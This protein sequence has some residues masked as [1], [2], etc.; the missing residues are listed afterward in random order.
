MGEV[1]RARDTRLDRAVAIKVLP[2]RLSGTTSMR[3]RFEREVRTVSQLSHPNICAVYDVGRDGDMG[4]VVM[5]YLD[6]ETLAQRIAKGPLPLH[7]AVRIAAQLADALDQ[8]HRR[9]I[10]HRDVKPGNVMLTRSGAKL[11]DFGL[12]KTAPTLVGGGDSGSDH[13]ALATQAH[14]TD[15]GTI[16]GTVQYMAPE[17]LEGREA[18]ARTDIFALGTV[19]YEMVTGRKAFEASS[20]ASVIISIMSTTPP[21]LSSV[22]P[23]VPPLL[24][25][26]VHAC[27]EKDP[28]DRVQT[29]HDVLLQLRWIQESSH[30]STLADRPATSSIVRRAVA[31]TWVP[32]TIAATTM[33]GAAWL[34]VPRSQA[35]AETAPP[36]RSSILL[37]ERIALAS[38]A[39]SPAGDRIVFSG[40]DQT[41]RNQLWVRPLDSE[42]ATRLAGT[43]GGILPFWSPD[44]KDIGF[45]A[46]KTLKR[47]DVTG[48]APVSLYG[49][50]GVSGTWT[51]RGDI[52]FSG[53]TG[54]ILRIAAD[55]GKASPVTA[56]DARRG[57]T[58]HRYPAMLPD[59]R[60][61]LFLAMNPASTPADPTNQI[62]VGTLDGAPTKSLLPAS[63]NPLYANGFLL[64]TRGSADGGSLLAQP[65]D[66]TR[67]E[68]TG[69]VTTV[70]S[71]VAV[72]GEFAGL[73]SVSVST[74]GTL[75]FDASRQLTRLAFYDRAGR[76]TA[77]FGEPALR[78]NPSLAPDGTHV[79]YNVYD[80]NNQT[81]QIW[82]ADL[83]R[84]VETR[85]T[86]PPGSSRVP[87][88]SPDGTRIAYQSDAKHQEDIMIRLADGSGAVEAITDEAG[89]HMVQ[90]FSAD[91]RTLI[92]YDREP[93]GE[94]LVGITAYPL[95]GDRKSYPVVP[96]RSDNIGRIG[97]A[98]LSPDGRWLAYNTDESGRW[99]VVV[100]SFPAGKNKVQISNA[101]GANP[102]WTRAGRELLYDAPDKQI[103]SVAILPGRFQAA[104]PMPLFMK[105]EGSADHWDVT[106][107]GE[108]F[109]FAVPVL[110]SSSVPLTLVQ[111]WTAALKH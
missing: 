104:S 56:L 47:V 78:A 75:L 27:L 65:F 36:V 9:G 110:K 83:Q 58:S 39:I 45:F 94:R 98:S 16:L 2:S 62:C 71:H 19:L 106:P 48:G 99:E 108:R 96:R 89:Q 15:R 100:V 21:S 30:S 77:Q 111:H 55:G 92:A 25:R 26:L 66:P 93:A 81:T 37:P 72:H 60:H 84:G 43:E 29:A 67:L 82:I 20:Q 52:L 17:Q 86:S 50:N 73:G 13:T 10:V 35:P 103:M 33:A 31:M 85:L 12:A 70:N 79:G 6:G 102:R 57:E 11:L 32:W 87:I 105:P 59:G 42:T 53:A 68:T 64:F 38:A 97:R 3:E 44:G 4:F 61:F 63:F 41:G 107:D 34:A 8:A 46:D 101:G 5:E 22:V 24:D 28:D 40:A 1:Y 90:A 7:H 54:P 95:D 69:P 109:V 49:V 88:W 91:G 80:P 76:L 14:L 18:D 51:S 23:S 74:N